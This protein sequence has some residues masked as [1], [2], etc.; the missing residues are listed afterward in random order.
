[1]KSSRFIFCFLML[2]AILS[3]QQNSK[4]FPQA[5]LN[6]AS[7]QVTE[8][9][10]T[11]SPQVHQ[12]QMGQAAQGNSIWPL[13]KRLDDL[14]QN[15]VKKVAGTS[16]LQLHDTIVVGYTPNDTLKITGYWTHSGPILVMGNGVLLIK[17]AT[18]IDSG[19][20]Y[21]FQNGQMIAD[22]SS[23]TFPQQYF[24]QRSLLAVQNGSVTIR[25][26]SFDYS[27]MSH[28]L[29]IANDAHVTMNQVHQRDWTTCGLTNKAVLSINGCNQ[30]GEYIL[31]DS[32]TTNFKHTD[33]LLLWHQFPDTAL[34]N[35]AFPNG[36]TVYNYHF[37]HSISGIHGIEY[38]VNAD[39]C[40]DVMW[41]M[42]PVNGSDV[43][44]SNSKIRAIGVWFQH[45]DT[46]QVSRLYDNSGYTNFVAP[47]ADRNLHLIN[48]QVQTWSLYVFDHSHIDVDS[49]QVGEI[50]TQARSSVLSTIPFLLDGSGGYYW[51]TDSSSIFTFGASV[52]SY[53]R[54]ERNGFFVLDYGYTP[55][56]AP[57]AIGKSVMVCVQSN[58]MADP[59]AYEAATAWMAKAEGPDTTYTN[60]HV[61]VLGSAWIDWGPAG[62]GW[63]DFAKYSIYYQA[64][65]SS[66][67]IRI[68]KDSLQEIHHGTIASWNTNGLGSGNYLLK[69]TVKNNFNDSV[70]AIMPVTLLPGAAAGIQEQKPLTNTLDV[71][72]NPAG[73]AVTLH[74][75]HYENARLSIY[76]AF[77][78][79]IE[80]SELHAATTSI[81]M[82]AFS[83]GIYIFRCVQNGQ[84]TGQS[85]IIKE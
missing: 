46:V 32:C 39:S 60:M 61:P 40:H 8:K 20:V 47:L 1:M 44:I 68:V 16:W 45:N 70:E 5:Q 13:L 33:T 76:N 31:S 52:Y 18:V 11:V 74:L 25:H 41:A 66:A 71:Y 10:P 19:D 64:P 12:K 82:S 53:A 62:T 7:K 79:L 24:Y 35:F 48:S 49:V 58:C 4:R 30:A 38:Q 73:N 84:V 29:V 26:C 55:F 80:E 54:S 2:C 28:N 83:Q 15:G 59:V 65:S 22:S 37:N 51:A 75:P 67:W 34:I 27:G 9:Y 36:D 3:A 6:L 72:P 57:Q 85:R 23:L 14:K 81:D 50:G 17:H 77:G 69:L 63:M 42:M 43:T 56:S 78:Q 21:V